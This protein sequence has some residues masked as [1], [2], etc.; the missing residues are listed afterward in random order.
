MQITFSAAR[1]ATNRRIRGSASSTND[2]GLHLFRLVL[3][4]ILTTIIVLKT[5]FKIV[6]ALFYWLQLEYSQYCRSTA[7]ISKVYIYILEKSM[8]SFGKNWSGLKDVNLKHL[9][10]KNPF[11]L[12]SAGTLWFPQDPV[13]KPWAPF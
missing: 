4:F 11:T 9:S 1:W 6:R 12:K 3:N 2:F 13:F 8:R 7:T 5:P 10:L